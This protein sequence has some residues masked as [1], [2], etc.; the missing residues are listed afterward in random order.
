[1]N[2]V[3][4]TGG[5][6]VFGKFLIDDLIKND[7]NLVL[8]IRAKSQTEAEDRTKKLLKPYSKSKDKIKVL[9]CDLTDD[10]LG[11]NSEDFTKL[12][13]ETT[14]ILHAA[15]STRFTLPLIEARR[16][17]VETTKKLVSFAKNCNKLQ[18][19][20]FVST[21]F[22]AGK[23]SGIILENEFEHDS[24]FL[25]TYEESKFEAEK[26]VRNEVSSIPI[27]IFRPSLIVTPYQKSSHSPVSALTLGLFL[28][29]KGFLPILPGNENNKLDIIE[30]ALASQV[31]IKLLLKKRLAHLTYHVTSANNSPQIK[32]LIA[33]I[34]GQSKKKLPIRFCGSMEEFTRE[35]KKV[36]RFRPD[37]I[38]IYKKTQSFLP[39]LAYPKI[40]DNS[41]L[42]A[43]LGT[44]TFSTEPIQELRALLK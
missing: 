15:A 14:H 34:E 16:N 28:A 33:L 2:T 9:N 19:F 21:A 13:K 11:L 10:K 29:R 17:N 22:V 8:L 41:N 44:K 30:G 42:L 1:M 4:L 38:A 27:T 6:G 39:E 25:N 40:F 7:L 5:T 26:A 37:L 24:G 23:R 3:L 36:T 20:G 31:I 18:R 43:E 35:L 32:D 12:T